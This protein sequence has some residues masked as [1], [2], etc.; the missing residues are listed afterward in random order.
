[1]TSLY[2]ETA[3]TVPQIPKDID[4][5]EE[6]IG[7]KLPSDYREFIL[8]NNG[9]S[10]IAEN[11]KGLDDEDYMVDHFYG[12]HMNYKVYDLHNAY[13]TYS[14]RIP[15]QFIP[16]GCDPGGNQ[17][18]LGIGGDHRGKVYFWE[19]EEEHTPPTTANMS[20]VANNFS[21]FI[22]RLFGGEKATK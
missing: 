2:S 10:P 16:V 3:Y 13:T 22:T 15:P 7:T 19:H 8:K 11:L 20:L 5:F 14:D 21:E 17:F 18:C 9:G 4:I 1:M 12:F 6:R